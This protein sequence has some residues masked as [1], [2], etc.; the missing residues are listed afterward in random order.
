QR[1]GERAAQKRA[2]HNAGQKPTPPEDADT[3]A[4]DNPHTSWHQKR[5][6][7]GEQPDHGSDRAHD[8]RPKYHVRDPSHGQPHGGGIVGREHAGSPSSLSVKRE[9]LNASSH[10]LLP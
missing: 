2:D 3:H 4:E 1:P 5:S 8:R 6:R 7:A 10:F 9:P